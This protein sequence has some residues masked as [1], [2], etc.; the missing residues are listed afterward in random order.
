VY[1]VMQDVIGR[2]ETRNRQHSPF[3]TVRAHSEDE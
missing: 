2:Y 1:A 3:M